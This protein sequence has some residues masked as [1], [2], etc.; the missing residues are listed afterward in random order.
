MVRAIHSSR[1]TVTRR[2]AGSPLRLVKAGD[3][4]WVKEKFTVESVRKNNDC[5][6]AGITYAADGAAET[7][8]VNDVKILSQVKRKKNGRL[9]VAPAIFMPRQA[10]RLTLRVIEVRSEK[11][12]DITLEQVRSEGVVVY[13]S[14]ANSEQA[15]RSL[16]RDLWDSLHSNPGE[17]WA[18]NPDVIAIEFT[19]LT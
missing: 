1:K 14:E 10:A 7:V 16:F 6:V 17:R 19:R 12:H 13:G 4:L 15:W 18:D 8:P 2:L 9:A 11:L 3:L 5:P